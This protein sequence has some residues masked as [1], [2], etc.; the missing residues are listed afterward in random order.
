[1]S[2]I[3]TGNVRLDTQ[4]LRIAAPLQEALENIRPAAEAK[5]IAITLDMD[6]LVGMVKVD[7]SRLQQVFWNLLS[8]AVKF[9]EKGGQIGVT[10]RQDHGATRTT[11]TN[12]GI[13]IA[14]EFLPHVFDL[15][16]Q[17]DGE[18]T[19]QYSG[20]GLGL[21]ISKQLVDL[22]GG[23]I[24]AASDGVGCGA[25]FTVSMPLYVPTS[26][27]IADDCSHAHSADAASPGLVVE[28]SD[29]ALYG[30]DVL[31]VDD[32]AD[33]LELFRLLLENAGATVRTV[34]GGR[35]AIREFDTC[36]PDVLVTDLGLPGMDGYDVLRQVRARPQQDGRCVPAVAVTAYARM[37]DHTKSLAAG[38]NA[39]I[40]KPIEPTTFVAALIAVVKQ[41]RPSI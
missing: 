23:A 24:T 13:G 18:Y 22:H 5:H 4:P 25:T 2:R 26:R 11:I 36:P 30:L 19:R 40:A 8:N 9:T 21:A 16:R 1:M 6:P 15:F 39:H 7:A 27:E 3:T 14:P 17:A 12:T 20:L 35:E 33:A 38:F 29:G 37:Y 41:S 31:V 34:A 32:E 10:L 28:E